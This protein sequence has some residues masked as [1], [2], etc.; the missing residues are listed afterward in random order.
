[1]GIGI[2]VSE[3][4]FCTLYVVD[5]ICISGYMLRR[6]HPKNDYSDTLVSSPLISPS[7]PADPSSA[8]RGAF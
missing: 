4:E 3:I 6:A 1:M 5:E 7:S 2:S 8:D